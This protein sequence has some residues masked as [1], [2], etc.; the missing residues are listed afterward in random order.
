[1]PI[2]IM[3]IAVFG[4]G[5]WRGYSRGIIGTVFNLAAYIFGITLAFKITPVTTTILE[6]MFHSENPTMYLAAFVVNIV[7]IMFVLRMAAR[8]MEGVLQAA[9]LGIVNQTL[10]GLL[11]G[12]F[13]VVVYSVMLWFAVKVQFVNDATIGES[14]AYPFLKELPGRAKNLAIRFKPL[15]QEVWGSSLNWMDRLQTYG[16]KET[17]RDKARIYEVPDDRPAIEGAPEERSPSQPK[18]N[19]PEDS[20]GIEE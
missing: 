17:Q 2:D 3:F 20:D 16:E 4:Y 19:Y 5:F 13:S 6:K 15:A 18:P 11:L 1:M 10:G 9:Y 8:S 12:S 14:R 7:F